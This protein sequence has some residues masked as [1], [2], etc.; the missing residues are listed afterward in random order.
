MLQVIAG[1]ASAVVG[2][3][4]KNP[5][6]K[7]VAATM[8][9]AVSMAEPLALWAHIDHRDAHITYVIV[10]VAGL[11]MFLVLFRNRTRQGIRSSVLALAA[12]YPLAVVL[13]LGARGCASQV[14]ASRPANSR[15]C[16]PPPRRGR[17]RLFQLAGQVT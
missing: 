14:Q 17:D 3:G 4:L 8:L 1:P 10:A 15:L 13:E 11:A 5:A 16:Y 2:S 6:R 7:L 9:A 12:L